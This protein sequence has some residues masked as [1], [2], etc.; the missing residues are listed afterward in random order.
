M[1]KSEVEKKIQQETGQV[2]ITKTQL[3]KC[4]GIKRAEH[5]DRYLDGLDKIDGKYYFVP[6]VAKRLMERMT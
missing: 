3:A 2:F 5:V 1:L 4:M 6:D